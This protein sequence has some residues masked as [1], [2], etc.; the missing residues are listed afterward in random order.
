[1]LKELF[2]SIWMK[3]QAAA[4]SERTVTELYAGRDGRTVILPSGDT[5]KIYYDPPARDHECEHL[6]DFI[7]T[8]K[9]F[10]AA[11]KPISTWIDT[12]QKAIT[13]LLDDSANSQRDETITYRLQT[14]ERWRTVTKLAEKSY[15]QRAFIRLL[16]IELAGAIPDSLRPKISKLDFVTTAGIRTDIQPGRERGTREFAADLAQ[17]GEIPEDIAIT[18]PVFIDPLIDQHYT[19]RA[20]LEYSVPPNTLEF[21]LTPLPDEIEK[22]WQAAIFRLKATLDENLAGGDTVIPVTIGRP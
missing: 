6:E 3:S 20:A 17:S 9:R 5:Q 4:K 2:E 13:A 21:R 16:R 10:A 7:E 1:M 19:I 22:A 14:T 12:K 8:T 15:D 11:G 18:V